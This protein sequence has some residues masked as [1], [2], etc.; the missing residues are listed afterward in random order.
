MG[1]H[2]YVARVD[3]A[4]GCAFTG[5]TFNR[6]LQARDLV[7]GAVT[8]RGVQADDGHGFVPLAGLRLDD[9][10]AWRPGQVGYGASVRLTAAGDDALATT[11]RST[12]GSSPVLAYADTPQSVPVVAAPGSTTTAAAHGG[13]DDFS[14]ATLAYTVVRRASPL[15]SVLDTGAIADLDYLRIRAAALRLRVDVDGV[16]RPAR[17]PTTP[18]LGCVT[19]GC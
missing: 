15:P 14:G 5:I 6:T 7:T 11:F 4:E 2:D 1:G 13:V 3:C 17:A 8:V 12:D 10:S 19:P 9:P 18:S 16:A